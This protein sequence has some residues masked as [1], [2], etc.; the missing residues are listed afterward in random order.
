[1]EQLKAQTND[2]ERKSVAL[3]KRMIEMSEQIEKL[4]KMDEQLT[5]MKG[6]INQLLKKDQ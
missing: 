3:E 5:E 1:M 4:D 2:L 6:M